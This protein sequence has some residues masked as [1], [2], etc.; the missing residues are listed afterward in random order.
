MD[1]IGDGRLSEHKPVWPVTSQLEKRM[2]FNFTAPEKSHH[3]RVLSPGDKL[4]MI[5]LQSVPHSP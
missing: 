5:G 2:N 4:L 1:H 3:N